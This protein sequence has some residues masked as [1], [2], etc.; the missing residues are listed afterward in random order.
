MLASDKFF[1]II[2]LLLTHSAAADFKHPAAREPISLG[3]TCETVRTA[4]RNMSRE[5]LEAIAS[6]YGITNRQRAEAMRCIGRYGR[7]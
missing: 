7:L 1:A 2:R 5:K 3:I 6:A 4:V